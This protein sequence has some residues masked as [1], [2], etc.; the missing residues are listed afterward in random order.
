MINNHGT[1]A[2]YQDKDAATFRNNIL[3][4]SGTV[5]NFGAL[6]TAFKNL[7][8]KTNLSSSV[9]G[10]VAVLS[11]PSEYLAAL[12]QS[13]IA[14]LGLPKTGSYGSGSTFTCAAMPQAAGAELW[15]TSVLMPNGRVMFVPFNATRSITYNVDTDTYTVHSGSYPGGGAYNGACLMR[16]GRV[17]MGAYSSTKSRIFDFANNTSSIPAP[18]WAGTTAHLCP[19]LMPDGNIYMMTRSALTASIY[20]PSLDSASYVSRGFPTNAWQGGC[21]MADGRIY[22]CPSSI[23]SSFAFDPSTYTYTKLGGTYPGGSN[24]FVGSVLLPDGRIFN[25]PF[26]ATKAYIYN[27]STDT[28]TTSS[29]TF[30][31]SNAF[32]LGC[33]T[34]DGQVFMSPANQFR[35]W[36][37]NPQ[38]DTYW[39]ASSFDPAWHAGTLGYS[40]A[41]TL[42]DGRILSAPKQRINP[43]IFTVRKNEPARIP[44]MVLSQ[45]TQVF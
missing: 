43:R 32:L 31:G 29:V 4:G 22:H 41:H 17:F 33:L 35:P 1:I 36:I 5:S 7:N 11:N 30:P 13:I 44:E 10:Y 26:T 9:A 8:R 34:S 20:F 24:P 28:V 15:T 42:L 38:T 12:S 39:T 14:T 45:L 6:N 23:T 19:M 40:G 37:W 27:P 16:D 25:I 21:V 3:S 18:T 2:A